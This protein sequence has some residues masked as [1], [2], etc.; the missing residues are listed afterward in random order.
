MIAPFCLLHLNN[1]PAAI[2]HNRNT[3]QVIG[4][5]KV[6]NR[7]TFMCELGLTDELSEVILLIFE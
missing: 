4:F 6:T 2:S 3:E 7:V 1:A 5:L